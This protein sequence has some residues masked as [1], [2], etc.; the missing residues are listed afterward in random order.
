MFKKTTTTLLTH[1]I[2]RKAGLNVAV[3]GSSVG[4]A[5]DAMDRAG[6]GN[7]G[8]NREAR[9]DGHGRAPRR[10]EINSVIY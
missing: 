2:L 9:R 5:S 4:H 7:V 10:L 3:G 1:H 6:L 8:G